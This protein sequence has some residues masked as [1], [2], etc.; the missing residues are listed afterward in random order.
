[1]ANWKEIIC[2]H[3]DSRNYTSHGAPGKYPIK[4]T[5]LLIHSTGE[6]TTALKRYVQPSLE[7][8]NYKN[9]IKTIGENKNGNSWNRS[10]S[11]GVHYML[12]K[13]ADGSYAVAQML[14]DNICAWGVGS[15]KKG[16][17][18]YNP[19]YIQIEIQDGNPI[20]ET[21]PIAVE[22]AVKKCKEYGWTAD[23]IT[24]HY[25]ARALGYGSAHGDPKPYFDKGGKTM[26]GF[27]ADV[28]ALLG[29][30]KK[31]DDRPIAVGDY[32]VFNGSKQ[33][34]SCIKA[35]G[36]AKTAKP[37]TAIVKAI[38]EGKKHP[39]M[40]QGAKAAEG[41][42][43]SVNGFVNKADVQKLDIVRKD[44]EIAVGDTVMFTGTKQWTSC[45][46]ADDKAKTAK[47]GS[48]VISAIYK[49]TKHPYMIKGAKVEGKAKASVCG[50]VN[51]DDIIK[52]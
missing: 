14:P 39:Y 18:N 21:Y 32:I 25:E 9:L 44:K 5:G 48:A 46:K 30:S 11:K 40:I 3:Y 12:G 50:F 1:M 16:S 8:P 7:D 19:A 33:W 49:G 41:D 43:A 47:A 24:S 26:D 2:I 17:Y 23:N 29:G 10:V 52:A 27:R 34:T 31:P 15:G 20:E 22:W 45:V 35:D 28:A 38:Y 51:A 42:K 6:G 36:D 37:G 13:C 4:P